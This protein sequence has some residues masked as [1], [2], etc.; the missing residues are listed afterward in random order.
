MARLNAAADE[1]GSTIAAA[2]RRAG[3]TYAGVGS[4]FARHAVCDDPEWAV[5][6][7]SVVDAHRGAVRLH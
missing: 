4:R 5:L 2:A 1:L 6:P 3:F 7:W